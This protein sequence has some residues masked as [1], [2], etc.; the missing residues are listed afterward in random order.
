MGLLNKVR[1]VLNSISREIDSAL[2][3]QEL[4]NA[5]AEQTLKEELRLAALMQEKKAAE[6]TAKFNALMAEIEKDIKAIESDVGDR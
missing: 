4:K 1:I 2:A 5:K 3:H 6:R